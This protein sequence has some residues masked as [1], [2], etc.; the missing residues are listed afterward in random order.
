M[1]ADSQSDENFVP[2]IIVVRNLVDIPP[3]H[4]WWKNY[5]YFYDSVPFP[6][7]SQRSP[8]DANGPH[9]F[10][11]ATTSHLQLI[12]K[13]N[14]NKTLAPM[15]LHNHA[16]SLDRF[17]NSLRGASYETI[18]NTRFLGVSWLYLAYGP[19]AVLFF[20]GYWFMARGPSA[21]LFFKLFH[22]R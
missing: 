14:W 20:Y 13:R 18:R 5:M 15:Q 12:C 1:F 21:K 19:W 22:S 3:Y 16:H 8:F 2:S 6:S 17:L 10:P 4:C 7:D 9:F 11:K